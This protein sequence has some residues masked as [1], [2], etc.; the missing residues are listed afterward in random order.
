M[1]DRS[2]Q[3]GLAKD[4]RAGRKTAEAPA[5]LPAGCRLTHHDLYL[6]AEGTHYRLADRLGA[7]RATVEGQDGVAF[8]VWAPN[9]RRVSVIG[10]FNGWDPRRNELVRLPKAGPFL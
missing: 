4:G 9:A 6:F 10:E 8:A 2:E 7:H 1:T 5:P 3:E